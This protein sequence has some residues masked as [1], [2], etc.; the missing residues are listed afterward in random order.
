VTSHLKISKEF[1]NFENLLRQVVQVPHSE[2][3]AKLEA[4]KRTKKEKRPKA[5]DASRASN[6]K[7]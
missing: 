7:D 3:K 2:I 5:S 1:Q 6:D 4:E